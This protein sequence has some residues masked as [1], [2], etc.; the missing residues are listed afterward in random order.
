METI[1]VVSMQQKCSE[2]NAYGI[3]DYFGVFEVA[4]G[5]TPTI[6]AALSAPPDSWAEGD[7][8]A[9]QEL[10]YHHADSPRDHMK[11]L[12]IAMA[13][14]AVVSKGVQRISMNN[15]STT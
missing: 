5:G 3:C 6:T 11:K 4:T 7:P 15:T 12:L 1:I 10:L 14:V 13:L 8:G 2:S 9:L